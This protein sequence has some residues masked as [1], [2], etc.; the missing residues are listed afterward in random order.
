MTNIDDT[1]R[2]ALRNDAGD[3]T[4]DDH[5]LGMF[6]MM[7]E[8]FRSRLRWWAVLV[9][10][11]IFAFLAVAIVAAVQFFGAEAVR[12]QILW[13]TVFIVSTQAIGLLKSWWWNQMDRNALTREIKRLELRIALLQGREAAP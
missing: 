11:Y 10:I 2:E 5:E 6:E 3:A 4:F 1:I 13:A 7:G 8:T 12:S 9:M